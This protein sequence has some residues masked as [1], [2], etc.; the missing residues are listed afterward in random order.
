[1]FP[2]ARAAGA[3]NQRPRGTNGSKSALGRSSGHLYI[4]AART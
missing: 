2:T 3:T 1:V 4:D